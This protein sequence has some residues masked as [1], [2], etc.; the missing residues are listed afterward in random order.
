MMNRHALY[1][2]AVSLAAAGTPALAGDRAVEELIAGLE[3]RD[4][5]KLK[6]IAGV[7]A[8]GEKAAAAAPALVEM[9]AV[10]NEDVRL[11]AAIALGK[12]GSAAVKPLDKAV[13]SG[14]PD[15]RFY[16]VWALAF[17]GPPARAATPSVAAALSDTSA[18]VRRKAAYALGRI[19]AD[20]KVVVPALVTALHDPDAD[21]RQAAEGALPKMGKAAVPALLR[22]LANDKPGAHLQAIAVL[23]A[24]G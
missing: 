1:A 19:D 11:A 15:V 3:K 7:E 17:V 24:I 20:A 14:D 22:A 18:Q 6:A 5:G 10:N 9:L 8:M 4:S 12:I 21:V 23:G 16:A 13:R 2:L